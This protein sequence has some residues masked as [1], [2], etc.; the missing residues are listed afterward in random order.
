[1]TRNVANIM[2]WLCHIPLWNHYRKQ[3]WH[4]FRGSGSDKTRRSN[5]VEQ[6]IY[7]FV[8][9]RP[10]TVSGPI[11]LPEESM[12]NPHTTHDGW[13]IQSTSC[14][15]QQAYVTKMQGSKSTR[16]LLSALLQQKIPKAVIP[17]WNKI[18]LKNFRPKPQPSVDRPNFY[19]LRES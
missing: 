1:M 11:T 2:I 12:T 10:D 16:R 17:C 14:W 15:T 8:V 19:V 13:P 9:A 18:I 7:E 3:M 4:T 5:N 6:V